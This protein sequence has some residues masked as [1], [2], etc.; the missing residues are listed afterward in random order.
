MDKITQEEYFELL[1]NRGNEKLS[2]RAKY[3]T[4]NAT[5]IIGENTSFEFGK[6]FFLGDFVTIMDDILKVQVDLQ[7]TGVT[8]SLTSDGEITDLIFGEE[9]MTIFK[10]VKNNERRI[11][12]G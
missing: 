9:K 2:E 3:I 11:N 8:K 4:F 6:D 7:I 12:N 1:R 5:P 10:R